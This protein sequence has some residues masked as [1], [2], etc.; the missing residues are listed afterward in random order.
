MNLTNKSMFGAWFIAASVGNAAALEGLTSCLLEPNETIQVGSAVHGVLHRVR[1]SRGDNVKAGQVIAEL[2]A[3]VERAAVD[4]AEARVAYTSRRAGRSEELFQQKFVSPGEKDDLDTE[5]E[6]SRLQLVEA[7]E[8]LRQRTIRSP[9]SGV[10]VDRF[11]GPGEYV[12]DQHI[13]TLAAL[14]PLHVELILP[15][16]YYGRIAPGMNIG[17][18]PAIGDGATHQAKVAV[19]DKI[20]DAASETFGV[21]L[22]L[23]NPDQSIPAGIQC[24][25]ELDGLLKADVNP[26][27]R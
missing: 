22:E 18:K 11:R 16:R 1:V 13:V 5:A 10:V 15:L 24:V 25:A 8:R 12:Q 17:I 4:V 2:K 23:P 14:D 7:K 3:S 9:I 21:R 19:V 6:I 27:M 20:I 26:P